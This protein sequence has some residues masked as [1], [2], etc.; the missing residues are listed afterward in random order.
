MN[1]AVNV[2]LKVRKLVL[3]M[4]NPIFYVIAYVVAFALADQGGMFND[5]VM[6]LW[7]LMKD[8]TS[9]AFLAGTGEAQKDVHMML[10]FLLPSFVAF[11]WWALEMVT[12]VRW[13]LE[14]KGF[15]LG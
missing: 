5:A 8:F 3:F 10:T 14:R 9:Y 2:Y 4:A 12:G 13:I 6:G 15:N 7:G 1:T 11:A